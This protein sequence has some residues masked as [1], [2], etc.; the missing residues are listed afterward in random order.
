MTPTAVPWQNSDVLNGGVF[1]SD[2]TTLYLYGGV[3]ASAPAGD[4][5]W[6]YHVPSG[7]WQENIVMGDGNYQM[8]GRGS[9]LFASDPGTATSVF[10]GG[11]R[12]DV[13]GMLEFWSSES[14]GLSWTNLSSPSC[15]SLGSPGPQ[16][17]EGHM[18]Y[19]PIGNRGILVAMG[20]YD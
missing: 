5:I 3:N 8:G 20:G 14:A 2:N 18:V 16:R 7:R 12:T 6:S 13:D 1:W 10:S 9:G 15:T 17:L 4:A 11:L 19:L